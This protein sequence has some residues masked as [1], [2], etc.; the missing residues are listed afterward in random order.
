MVE[1]ILSGAQLACLKA[2][3][4]IGSE[5]SAVLG[6]AMSFGSKAVQPRT[7]R[8]QVHASDRDAIALG[9]PAVLP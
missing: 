3:V 8:S 1:F 9:G 6:R 5:E 2:A 4:T 7:V